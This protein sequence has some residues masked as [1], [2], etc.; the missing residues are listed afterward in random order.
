MSE[1]DPGIPDRTLHD[2]IEQSEPARLDNLI[3]PHAA[4]AACDE[5]DTDLDDSDVELADDESGPES[6]L[7]G[8]DQ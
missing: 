1:A 4:H 5:G 3:P 8:A 7:S 6:N 2:E